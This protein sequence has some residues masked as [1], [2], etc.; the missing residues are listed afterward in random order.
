MLTALTWTHPV[1]GEVTE[2]LFP[3]HELPARQAFAQLGIDY[4]TRLV[5]DVRCHHCDGWRPWQSPRRPDA[6]ADQAPA[7]PGGDVP[8][9]TG[10]GW[11]QDSSLTRRRL[12]K[13]PM[14]FA[15]SSKMRYPC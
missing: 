2:L 4:T 6:Q 13:I 8:P 14:R 3:A 10:A 7:S 5:A 12:S 15:T 11:F 9:P 1:H